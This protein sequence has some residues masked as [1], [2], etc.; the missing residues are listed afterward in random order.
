LSRVL[1]REAIVCHADT[2]C[3]AI[4]T[5][6]VALQADC[7][8]GWQ[9][10]FTAAGDVEALHIPAPAP[11]V[12]RDGLWQA[13]CFE[14]FL[15]LAGTRYV[16]VNLSPSGAFACYQFDG[17]RVGMRPLALSRPEM[18]W[19]CGDGALQLSTRIGSNDL[20]WDQV[21]QMGL[22]AVIEEASGAKSYWALAHPPGRPDF[23]DRSCF[24][25]Q[26]PPRS[27]A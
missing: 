22:S 19:A 2:P 23:H 25:L 21:E 3:A 13:T 9:V 12:H 7:D 10:E 27:A 17:Y 4:T 8:G 16:E 15:G 20:P 24:T 5:L 26:L 14:M 11:A 1:A 18:M 6:H